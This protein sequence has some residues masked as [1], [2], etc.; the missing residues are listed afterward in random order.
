MSWEFDIENVAG[1]RSGTATIEPGV[2]AVRASNWQGKSSLLAAIRTVLGTDAT[3]TEGE[4]GGRV[5]LVTDADTFVVELER[6]GGRVVRRGDE[7]LT[8]EYERVCATHFAFLDEDNPVRAAV[9][10][11]ENLEDVLT[12]PLDFENIDAQIVDTR[13]ELDQVERERERAETARTKLPAAERRVEQLDAEVAD[14]GERR[15]ELRDE[16]AATAEGARDELSSLRAERDQVADRVERLEGA[17]ERTRDQLEEKRAE[18]ADLTVPDDEDVAAA[19]AEAR[20]AL[21]TVEREVELLR[22]IYEANRRVL[23]EDRLDLLTDVERGL[24]DDTVACWVCGSAAERRAFDDRLAD[25][26]ERITDRNERV[27]EHRARVEELTERRDRIKDHRR[28]RADLD[29]TVADLERTLTER[30]ESLDTARERLDELNERVEEAS[31]T[32]EATDTELT[33]VEGELKYKRAA[34]EDAREERDRLATEADQLAVLADERERLRGELERLRS[35]KDRV[36]ERTRAAFDDAIREASARFET[37]FETARLTSTFELVVAREGREASLD[38]LSEGEVELLGVVAALAGHEAYDVGETVP[39]I[40]VD[41]LGG[42]AAENLAT[43]VSFLDGRADHLVLTA[44]P[45]HTTFE[46][47]EIDPA[48]WSVVSDAAG[49][50]PTA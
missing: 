19:L 31:A 45:E 21:Q 48:D 50:A 11:G 14:L 26:G 1:I 7:L 24:L 23:D 47:H 36:K 13:E 12:A 44:Y 6:E 20:D 28:Q 34:L 2:N 25:L 33:D 38:A 37:S 42:L 40:L 16:E 30:S 41:G 18:R 32:V 17:V 10:N 46:G 29:S 15:D 39:V 5:R 9:R 35:R 43:L 49:D 4:S 22:S 3:L 8:D 27:A